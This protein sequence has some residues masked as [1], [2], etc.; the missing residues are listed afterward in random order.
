MLL[1]TT[2]R[3]YPAPGSAVR[4]LT[5]YWIAADSLRW[6]TAFGA[7][8]A[9]TDAAT[10]EHWIEQLSTACRTY[11]MTRRPDAAA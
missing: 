4:V 10:L 9:A 8:F 5:A 7:D 2:T 11:L 3:D 1:V 6:R